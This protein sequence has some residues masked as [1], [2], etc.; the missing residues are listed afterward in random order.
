MSKHIVAKVDEIPAGGRKIVEVN[1]RS[2]GVFNINGEF[3][4][5]LP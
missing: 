1:G 3:F 4:H 2:I 5:G